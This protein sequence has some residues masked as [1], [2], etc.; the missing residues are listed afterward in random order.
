[1]HVPAAAH[2]V[3]FVV[4]T[5]ALSGMNCNLYLETRMVFSLSRAGYAPARLGRVSETGI[6]I[7]ALALS[8]FG[9]AVATAVAISFPGSAYVYLF[10]VSLFGALFVWLMIF[11]THLS[12]RKYRRR[13]RGRALPVHMPFFPVTTILGGLAVFGITV[14]TWWVEG[15]RVTIEAGVPWL[16]VLSAYYFAHRRWRARRIAAAVD[17]T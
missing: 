5:A 16:I 6:P 2:I 17:R 13:H 12:F 1:M 8:T 11:I 14:S 9:L 15:M 7:A 10:G 4:L 3:N